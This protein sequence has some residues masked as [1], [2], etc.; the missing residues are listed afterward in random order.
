MR[1]DLVNFRSAGPAGSGVSLL[2]EWRVGAI[3][4]A[5]AVRDAKT[6]QLWLD[7]GGQ[8]HPARIASGD[9]N[10]P[11]SGEQLQLRVLRNSPVLALETLSS[12]LDADAESTIAGDALRRYVPRQESP[13]LMLANLAWMA[14][15]K[16]ASSNLPR[17]VVQ[18]AMQLWQS[19]P[20]SETL[21]D[22]KA[23]QTAILR[24]GVFLETNLA[25]GERGAA[26]AS[27]LKALMLTLNR[28]L[29]EHG[30]R[31]AAARADTAV[32]PPV[33]NARGPLTTL[34]SAPAT[35]SLV[36]TPAQQL[37]ELA[38][39]TDG[40]LARLTT[41][42]IS[43][44][45]PDPNVQSM[46][47][48]LPI[49]HEDRASVLRL[50]VERDGSRR[51]EAGKEAW[52]VEAALDLGMTGALHAKVTLT[53]RRIGVQLRAESPVIVDALSRR[54]SELEALLRDAGL[55]IDR[56][57]CLHGM[58]AGDAGARPARLLDVRA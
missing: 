20:G 36:D 34:Q 17:A 56:V 21:A 5:I 30:A 29:Q 57:V 2:S 16:N 26:V 10:G 15:G 47:I 42:Q 51:Q 48:E 55:E 12:T 33:P 52:S 53:G 49:R 11:R 24:S 4:Q 43:N 9:D 31:P 22:P 37:N 41:T 39:Q 44:S 14:S 6:N 35:F 3:L 23:L 28:A 1:V 7:I 58:P 25:A 19:L 54:A 45:A 13:A 38:R 32:N 8:L 40:A 18:A 27:D 46:L 50:R